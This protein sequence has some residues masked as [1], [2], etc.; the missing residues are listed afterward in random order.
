M[1]KNEVWP[2]WSKDSKIYGVWRMNRWNEMFFLHDDAIS[3]KLK[4]AQNFFGVGMVKN[5]SG[6]FGHGTLKFTVSEEWADR[7]N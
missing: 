7:M 2:V 4:A 5:G 3:Q 1:D 6:Q